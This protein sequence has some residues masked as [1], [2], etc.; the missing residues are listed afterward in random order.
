MNLLVIANHD[1]QQVDPSSLSVIEFARQVAGE[2]GL[3]QV[4]LLGYQIDDA[5]EQIHRQ[6]DQQEDQDDH[7]DAPL[8]D[9]YVPLEDG[10]HQKGPQARP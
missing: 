10:I 8:G 2:G 5:V 1:G 4:L 7:Q 9:R 3:V 6:V